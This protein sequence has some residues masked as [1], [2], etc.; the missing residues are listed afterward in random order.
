MEEIKE[1]LKELL[2]EFTRVTVIN[3]KVNEHDLKLFSHNERI[4]FLEL[5][6]ARRE[7]RDK[8]ILEKLNK[9]QLVTEELVTKPTKKWDLISA[10]AL[11]SVFSGIIGFFISHLLK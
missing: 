6:E 8:T 4:M 10:I 1:Y 9:I 2:S 11:A 7:E 3:S 5:S